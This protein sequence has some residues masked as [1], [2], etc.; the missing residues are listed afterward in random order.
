MGSLKVPSGSTCCSARS[1]GN[2]SS[3]AISGLLGQ[4]D[5]PFRAVGHGQPRGILLV[6]GHGPVAQ[7]GPV[8]LVVLAEQF[9]GQV[10]A[11]PVSLAHLRVDLDLH[12]S[13]RTCGVFWDESS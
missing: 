11:A 10:V 9:G 8:A 1:C 13:P 4:A 7:D 12:C 3:T 5:G 6:R 2:R